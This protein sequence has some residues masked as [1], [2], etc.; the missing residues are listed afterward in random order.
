[1]RVPP[2]TSIRSRWPGRAVRAGGKLV[3]ELDVEELRVGR[4]HLEVVDPVQRRMPEEG[5]APHALVVADHGLVEDGHT[6]APKVSTRRSPPTR[7]V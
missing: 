3:Q 1:M 6:A 2:L 4:V 7:R 5:R